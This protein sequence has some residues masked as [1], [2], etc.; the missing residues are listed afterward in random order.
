MP[1]RCK[2]SQEEQRKKISPTLEIPDS[3]YRRLS[4]ALK[5]NFTD[6]PKVGPSASSDRNQRKTEKV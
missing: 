4:D 1:E 6:L 2:E 5:T 3:E